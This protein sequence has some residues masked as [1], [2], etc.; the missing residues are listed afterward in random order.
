MG[1]YSVS[2]RVSS[3]A[4]SLTVLQIFILEGV[5]TCVL[6][7]GSYFLIV[8]FPELADRAGCQIPF[9]NE[10]EVAFVCARIEK[11]RHDVVPEP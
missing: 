11:D 2:F 3:L 6:A 1:M 10:K 5:V 8:D 9:L 7:L 4:A